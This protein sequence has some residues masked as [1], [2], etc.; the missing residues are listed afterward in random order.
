VIGT[1]TFPSGLRRCSVIVWLTTIALCIGNASSVRADRVIVTPSGATLAP[2]CA[3]VQ[4]IAAVSGRP[5]SDLWVSG[6]LNVFEFEAA[7]LEKPGNRANAVSAQVSILP[8]TF[9][10]PSISAGVRDIFDTTRQFGNVGY[11]GRSI[12]IAA[13]KTLLATELSPMPLRNMS[14]NAG[15]GTGVTGGIFG[16]VSSDLPF[17]V[18]EAIEYDGRALNYRVSRDFGSMA[19]VEYERLHGG[20]FLGIELSTPV[21]S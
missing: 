1:K 4:G 3:S 7:H 19:R 14:I 17:G 15:L 11:T 8:E 10:T 5:A 2:L 21:R 9:I 20:N 12:Y 18:R 16:S 13:G 6:S